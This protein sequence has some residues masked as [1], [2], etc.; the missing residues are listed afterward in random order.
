MATSTTD[1]S[2]LIRGKRKALDDYMYQEP[3]A[4]DPGLSDHPDDAAASDVTD[5]LPEGVTAITIL[6]PDDPSDPEKFTY[7]KMDTGAWMVYP[8]GVPCE[9]G[10]S[11]IQMDHA[12]TESDYADM[13]SALEAAGATPAGE[14]D[15]EG[16][17]Y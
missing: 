7:E 11:R 6:A 4:A 13:D 2:N 14:E 9:T 17:G 15:S 3:G 1:M 10:K 16:E 12:A 5:A 8:P